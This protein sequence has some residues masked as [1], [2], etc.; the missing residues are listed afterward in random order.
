MEAWNDE[1][2]VRPIPIDDDPTLSQELPQ[3]APNDGDGPKR[4]WLPLVLA[5]VAVLI[6]VGSVATFGAVQDD[7]PPPLDVAALLDAPPE[8][9]D[10][11]TT[12]TL[13]NSLSETIPGIE[14]RLTL[15]VVGHN[16]PAALLWDPSFI[17]PK[18]NPFDAEPIED[19]V[20]SA[21]FD[22]SGRFLA[23][24]VETPGSVGATVSVGVP[25][26]VG[27]ADLTNVD[28]YLWHASEVGRFAWVA[29][30]ADGTPHLYTAKANPLGHT[31]A[32]GTDLGPI[33]DDEVLIRWDSRGFILDASGETTVLRGSEGAVVSTIDAAVVAASATT[34]ITTPPGSD[35][36]RLTEATLLTRSGE[37]ISNI[38][39]QGFSESQTEVDERIRTFAMSRS[40]DLVARIDMDPTQTRLEVSGPS[41]SALRILRHNDDVPPIGF[42]STDRYFVFASDGGNDLVF[43]DWNIGSIHELSIPDQYKVIAFDIG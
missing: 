12:T 16:G 34:M 7:D 15:I 28:S 17:L 38:L 27:N 42:T 25:T 33:D 26:D 22:S 31:L 9:A 35:R 43:V 14:D 20:Y 21:S 10:G 41:L 29:P 5:A 24:G 1:S 13:G 36:T 18:E 19:A 23:L 32:E 11:D 39:A 6:V 3:R 2:R 40:S 30:S 8:T 4:P 37:I